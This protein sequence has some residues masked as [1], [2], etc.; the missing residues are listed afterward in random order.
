LQNAIL[1]LKPCFG[2]L[3]GVK[4]PPTSLLLIYQRFARSLRR[5]YWVEGV[6]IADPAQLGKIATAV[7]VSANDA[8]KHELTN[9]TDEAI[10]AGAFGVPSFVVSSPEPRLYFGQDR[11]HF[12][13]TAA[14]VTSHALAAPLRL[15]A[16]T[17]PTVVRT[18]KCYFDFSSPWAYLG[19]MQVRHCGLGSVFVC[20]H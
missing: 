10:A 9:N 2:G 5:A 3:I 12:V 6:N 1:W 11:V 19:V 7:G 17:S 4:P 15:T 18:V 16:N 20:G 14:G 8:A 13:A